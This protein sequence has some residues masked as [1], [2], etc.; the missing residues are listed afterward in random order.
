MPGPVSRDA[1]RSGLAAGLCA[2]ALLLAARPLAAQ[3]YGATYVLP[4][5]GFAM[6]PA[7]RR[8]LPVTVTN[9]GTA[10][11]TPDV[12]HL[13]YHW[14]AGATEV[15]RDGA[16]TFL[17]HPV[18]PGTAVTLNATVAAFDP[19]ASP[20]PAYTL[21][22]DMVREGVTWFSTA[23]VATGD[24]PNVT[25]RE[26]SVCLLA[27]V[28]T[29]AV[30][31]TFPHIDH[32]TPPVLRPGGALLCSGGGFGAR[33]SGAVLKMAGA[34]TGSGLFAAGGPAASV[35][36]PL[37]DGRADLWRDTLFLVSVPADLTGF[38]RSRVTVHVEVGGAPS[39]ELPLTLEP[40]LEVRWVGVTNVANVACGGDGGGSHR[41]VCT[42]LGAVHA[43]GAHPN[44]LEFPTGD[45]GQDRFR[46]HVYN[47]W[48]FTEPLTM[49]LDHPGQATASGFHGGSPDLD[50]A[51][52]WHYDWDFTAAGVHYD[53]AIPIQGPR[54]VPF[55]R[56]AF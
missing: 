40:V 39:N 8:T 20:A 46:G 15:V 33:G 36:L 2:V 28:G 43:N 31:L 52:D 11:W 13:S 14:N 49:L 19:G 29:P 10:T 5:G 34:D 16:R 4:A 26:T 18:P 32:C 9:T 51:V 24:V 1:R 55:D 50:L 38:M 22:F 48:A 35:P 47:G 53:L 54:G 41:N 45:H 12:Y 30:H 21:K 7:D 27:L 3:P 17:P 56:P 25:V 44:P 6:C 23:G 42:P 37:Y